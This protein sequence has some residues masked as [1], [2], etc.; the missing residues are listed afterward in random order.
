MITKVAKQNLNNLSMQMILLAGNAREKIMQALTACEDKAYD[1]ADAYL[2]EA[3]E[4]IHQAHILQTETVQREA[5]EK[6]YYYSMLFTH[7]QDT[8][9]TIQSEYNLAIHMVAILRKL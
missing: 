3:I 5:M 8:L 4:E 1:T 9:M 2:A 7:A 6:E